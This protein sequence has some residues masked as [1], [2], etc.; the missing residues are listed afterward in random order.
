MVPFNTATIRSRVDG[1]I[2]K[3][4]F[5]E[6][7]LV[8]QGDPLVEIDPRPYQV[9][10]DQAQGQMV[11]DQ[12][13][14]QNATLNV[15]RDREAKEAISAQQLSTDV[16]AQA[17]A[18][19][20]VKIDQAAIDNAKLQLSYAHITAPIAGR[21][22]L[23]VVDEGNLVHA[24]DQT[25]LA[26]ITQLQPISVIFSLPEDDIP[27]VVSSMKENP[28]LK[29]DA[30]A[31]D[32]RTLLASGKLTTIDNQVDPTSGTFRVKAE[33]SNENGVLFPSQF[34]SA[35]MLAETIR[36]TTIV[37]SA[38]VQQ[39]P[40][41]SYVYVVKADKT[42]ELRKVKVTTSAGNEI[43][44]GSPRGPGAGDEAAIESGVLPDETVV[45]DGIDKLQNGSPVMLGDSGRGGSG[46]GAGRG[47]RP[48]KL[49]SIVM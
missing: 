35:R 33:F 4:N 1:Q 17:Q 36:D 2:M 7:Q 31:R 27:R 20:A 43:L 8:K 9:Q 41:F 48:S 16:A 10:L 32:L 49:A 6:G 28:N 19:G 47:N 13:L 30:Y 22:G 21:I 25:G 29:V 45:V 37:P 46:G 14:L 26:V 34:V 5:T 18:E 11:K 12:A 15:N 38:A 40:D 23:R 42:V 39:G 3:V 24:N 44:L